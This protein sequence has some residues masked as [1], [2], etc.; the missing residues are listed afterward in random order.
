MGV[1]ADKTTV[2][3]ME[4]S[5][6]EDESPS[7]EP[8]S[9]QENYPRF[10]IPHSGKSQSRDGPGRESLFLCSAIRKKGTA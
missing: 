7:N 3:S 6:P 2:V 9:R 1:A 4:K 5:N 10:H 8:E